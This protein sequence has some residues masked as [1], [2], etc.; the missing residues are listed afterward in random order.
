MMVKK[1]LMKPLVKLPVSGNLATLCEVLAGVDE[2]EARPDELHQAPLLA[3]R[4]APNVVV[5]NNICLG[6]GLSLGP[7]CSRWLRNDRCTR[8][9]I[10]GSKAHGEVPRFGALL[11]R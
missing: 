1:P 3:P 2:E 4:W 8:R 6:I 10:R 5:V 9:R 7:L 11:V